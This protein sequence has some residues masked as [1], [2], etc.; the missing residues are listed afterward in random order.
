MFKKLPLLLFCLA[1]SSLA[2]SQA[3]STTTSTSTSTTTSTTTTTASPAADSTD[4]EV[5]G[6]YDD[7]EKKEETQRSEKLKQ[8]LEK[9]ALPKETKFSDLARLSPFEDVAVISRKFL[10]KTGR[11]DLSASLA[12]TV[13]NPYYTNF[14]GDFAI[15]Y[16]FTEAWAVTLDYFVLT[17]NARDITDDLEEFANVEANSLVSPQSFYGTYVRWTPIY[18]K[19]SFFDEAIVPYDIYFRLGAGMTQTARKSGEA[20]VSAG[21]GQIFGVNKA[22]AFKWD[23]LWNYYQAEVVSQ[24]ETKKLSNSDIFLNVGV[25]FYFPEAKYR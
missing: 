18:G 19:M 12:F 17:S 5:E 1:L 15:G 14:G 10:P 22:F 11:F 20:T 3:E 9:P 7:Y 25:S 6:L 23:F 24:D 16:S 21:V 4:T 8:N 13:N 2:H